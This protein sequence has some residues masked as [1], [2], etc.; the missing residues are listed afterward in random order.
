LKTSVTKL[1]GTSSSD[2]ESDSVTA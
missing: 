1:T 2:G